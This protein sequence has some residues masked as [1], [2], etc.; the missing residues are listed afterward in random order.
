LESDPDFLLI[1]ACARSTGA[2][3]Q[4]EHYFS[5]NRQQKGYRIVLVVEFHP[6][7]G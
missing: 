2:R 4:F 3:D 5:K 6:L 1:A 7:R